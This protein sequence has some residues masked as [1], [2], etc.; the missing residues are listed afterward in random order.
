MS[1]WKSYR[2]ELE[3]IPDTRCH[4]YAKEIGSMEENRP[5]LTPMA[6][7]AKIGT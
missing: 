4:A 2:A 1:D 5:A 7:L 6:D 3:T